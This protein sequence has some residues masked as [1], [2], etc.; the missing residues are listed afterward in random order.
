[1]MSSSIAG[2]TAPTDFAILAQYLSIRILVL[3]PAAWI[4]VIKSFAHERFRVGKV[5]VD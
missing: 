5:Q 3:D 4:H 2:E 1:M